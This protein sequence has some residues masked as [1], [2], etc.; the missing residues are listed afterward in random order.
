MAT[1]LGTRGALWLSCAVGLLIP[2]LMTMS[3]VRRAR[4]LK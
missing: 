3:P 4:D 1:G 2:V